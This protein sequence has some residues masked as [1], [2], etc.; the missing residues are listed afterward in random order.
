MINPQVYRNRHP[1]VSLY[2]DM[3]Y[4]STQSCVNPFT[5]KL[6]RHSPNL[7][8][9]K[10][11]GEVVRICNIILFYP[12]KLWIAKIFILCDVIFLLRLQEKF[13][14]DHS[15]TQY[16]NFN[17]NAYK[18]RRYYKVWRYKHMDGRTD[19]WV[20]EWKRKSGA[21]S[22]LKV[23]AVVFSASFIPDLQHTCSRPSRNFHQY[24]YIRQMDQP[25]PGFSKH[26]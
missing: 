16:V 24:Y 10:S 21:D 18:V 13:D 2:Q 1:D 19:G 26:G 4:I 6:K 7:L 20:N 25:G 22:T 9:R 15:T 12:R 17:Y 23:L 8:K 5:N 11:I 3:Q 14:I